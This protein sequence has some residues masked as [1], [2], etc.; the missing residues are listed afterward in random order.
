MVFIVTELSYYKW[1]DPKVD[2]FYNKWHTLKT[3]IKVDNFS[4]TQKNY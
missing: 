2:F 1:A 3:T 4:G